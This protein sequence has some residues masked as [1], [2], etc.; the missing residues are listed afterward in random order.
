MPSPHAALSP[1]PAAV[2]A[3]SR[4]Q[5]SQAPA[6]SLQSPPG[7][8]GAAGGGVRSHT[9]ASKSRAGVARLWVALATP[10]LSRKDQDRRGQR[11]VFQ[12]PWGTGRVM[13][14][15]AVWTKDA[16]GLRETWSPAHCLLVPGHP[17][18]C[19]SQGA[20]S[21]TAE[22]SWL[23]PGKDPRMGMVGGHSEGGQQRPLST[24]PSHCMTPTCHGTHSLLETVIP[25]WHLG[26]LNQPVPRTPGKPYPELSQVDSL[27]PRP[28]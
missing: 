13:A 28:L 27:D 21:L 14:Q 12:V 17:G 22:L 25:H 20:P 7:A 3:G 15:T 8:V 26:P 5:L 18:F 19:V 6:G 24:T 23:C 4:L 16:E 9:V 11:A 1:S 2:Q 10:C